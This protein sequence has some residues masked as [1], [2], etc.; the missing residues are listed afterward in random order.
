MIRRTSPT[1]SQAA[2]SNVCG[3][4]REENRNIVRAQDD[5]TL[6]GKLMLNTKRFLGGM[7]YSTTA[8]ASIILYEYMLITRYG[9]GN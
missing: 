5:G 1:K 9:G 4:G 2:Q 3:T 7:A 6:T 8:A